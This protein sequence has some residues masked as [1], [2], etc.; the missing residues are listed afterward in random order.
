M[1][2]VFSC[3]QCGAENRARGGTD[4]SWRFRLPC[5]SCGGELVLT[6]DGGLRVDK[7]TEAAPLARSD[8]LTAPVR[9][10]DSD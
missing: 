5:S 6:W 8:D 3:P 9:R 1:Q 10:G 2:L 7:A 4:A